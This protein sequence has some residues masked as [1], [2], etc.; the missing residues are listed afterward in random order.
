M[1]FG[2]TFKRYQEENVDRTPVDPSRQTIIDFEAEKIKDLRKSPGFRQISLMDALLVVGFDPENKGLDLVLS[3][4]NDPDTRLE[5]RIAYGLLLGL[6]EKEVREYHQQIFER[7][8]RKIA[9]G[10]AGESAYADCL[11]Q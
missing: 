2:I 6:K 4:Y 9:L 11:T 3:R 8:I 10:M 1:V 5:H 7:K